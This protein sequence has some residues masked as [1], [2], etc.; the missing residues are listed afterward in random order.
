[1]DLAEA[2]HKPR[3]GPCLGDEQL[4]IDDLGR[5]DDRSCHAAPKGSGGIDRREA[6]DV[7]QGAVGNKMLEGWDRVRAG[8]ALVDRGGDAGVNPGIIGGQSEGGHPFEDVDVQID[9][10]RRHQ[11]AAELYHL[12]R[13]GREARTNGGDAVAVHRKI[14]AAIEAGRGIT[15]A[16]AAV[17]RNQWP[18]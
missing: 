12:P 7:G 2:A 11:L 6:A 18:L 14:A 3:V 16:R 8:A 1:M 13:V 15:N 5:M 9:P 17:V 4:D 10:A